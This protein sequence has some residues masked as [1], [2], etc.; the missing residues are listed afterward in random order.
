MA[1][2]GL[3]GDRYFDYKP[4]YKGQVTF[5]EWENLVSMWEALRVPPAERDP[6]ATRRNVIVEGMDLNALIGQEFCLQGIRFLGTEEC[7][8]CNWM[9][10][11]IHPGARAWM[12]GR[13]GLRARIL[14][15]GVLCLDATRTLA[16]S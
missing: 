1:G 8:P 16:A 12:E 6:S 10:G 9:N 15:D 14:S 4:D 5:F 13:G 7:K 2:H 11:A 3:V